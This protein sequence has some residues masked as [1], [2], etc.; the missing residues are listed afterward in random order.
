ML[1]LVKKCAVYFEPENW[2]VVRSKGKVRFVLLSGAAWALAMIV[3]HLV[4]ATLF[5]HIRPL[6]ALVQA[7]LLWPA[8]GLLFGLLFW[9][10]LEGR[11]L[12][13]HTQDG[14]RKKR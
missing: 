9:A 3:F 1:T 4:V 11:Y 13:S 14:L 7:A 12:E 5:L 8:C 6:F 10:A 2:S